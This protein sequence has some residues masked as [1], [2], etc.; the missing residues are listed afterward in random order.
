MLLLN[1]F[2][3][4]YLEFTWPIYR[5][6]KGSWNIDLSI[7]ILKHN[8]PLQSWASYIGMRVPKPRMFTYANE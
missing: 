5:V 6:Q 3:R 8:R 2:M 7:D 1:L 4:K